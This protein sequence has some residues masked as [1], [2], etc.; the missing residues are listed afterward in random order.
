VSAAVRV[1][2]KVLGL[3]ASTHANL[4]SDANATSLIGHS[5]AELSA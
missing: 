4:A 3:F 5:A 1:A 2:V